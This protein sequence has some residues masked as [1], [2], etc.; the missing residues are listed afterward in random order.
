[1]KTVAH[2][3]AA[4]LGLLLGGALSAAALL[5]GAASAATPRRPTLEVTVIHALHTDGG[6]SIDPRLKDL[7]PPVREPFVRYNVYKLLDTKNLPLEA[8]KPATNVLAN[9]RT[10]QVTLVDAVADAGAPRFHVRAEIGEPGKQAF[11]KLLEVT[12]SGNEPFFVGGQSY[13]GGTLL[14]ELVVRP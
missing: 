4:R 5:T 7:P 1:M 2:V 13:Q 12:A 10:L 14:I 6:V 3:G 11:L 9:G 8:G